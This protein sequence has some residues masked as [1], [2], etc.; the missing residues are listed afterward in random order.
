MVSAWSDASAILES[1]SEIVAEVARLMSLVDM[2]R[3][4]AY[5]ILGLNA[6]TFTPDEAE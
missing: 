4:G 3:P 5:V 6:D 1:G 2:I